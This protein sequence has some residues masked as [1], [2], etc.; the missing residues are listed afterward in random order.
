MKLRTR[1][2]TISFLFTC[3]LASCSSQVTTGAG[4]GGTTASGIPNATGGA[5]GNVAYASANVYCN[6]IFDSLRCGNFMLDS[7]SGPIPCDMPLQ[8]Q[9]PDAAL[10]IVVLDC[11]LIRQLSSGDIDAGDGDAGHANGY[12]IDYSYTPAHIILTGTIC[13]LVQSPGYHRIDLVRGC[14]GPV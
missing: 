2:F 10:V 1:L 3:T 6:G 5:T 9:P 4:A 12:F 14:G 7:S 8:V 13:G 11:N